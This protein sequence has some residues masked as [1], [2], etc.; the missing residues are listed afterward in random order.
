M[1]NNSKYNPLLLIFLAII[2]IVD[3]TTRFFNKCTTFLE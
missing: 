1:K 3:A 2:F